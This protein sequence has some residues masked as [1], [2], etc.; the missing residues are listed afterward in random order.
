FPHD[1]CV[2]HLFQRQASLTPDATA[3]RFGAESLSYARL[4]ALSNQLAHRLRLLG[5]RPGHVVALCVERSPLLFAGMLAILKAGA[6]YLPLD[7]T[8]PAQRRAFMLQDAAVQVIVGQ[9][10]L[11]DGFSDTRLAWLGVEE[12]T[13]TG[14]DAETPPESGATALDAAYVIYTSGSTSH[15][16]GVVVPHRALVN[17]TLAAIEQ[18][19]LRPEDRAL[20]FAS[21]SFDASAEEIFPTLCRGAT[22]VPRTEAMLEST[23]AFLDA[24]REHAIS[25]LNLPTA[26]WHELTADLGNGPTVLPDSVRLIIIGGEKASPEHLA[27]WRRQVGSHPR[28]VNTYGPT[29][30]TIVATLAELAESSVPDGAELPIGRP[31]RNVRVHVL[32][33]RLHPVPVGVTGELFIGGEGVAR[34]YL[35]RPDLTAERFLPDPFS[36]EPGAR[37]YRTGDLVRWRS[38]TGL[39]Y[40]GRNDHQVKLRG[41]RI[42][43]GEIEAQLLAHPH[44][45]DSV[46]APRAYSAHDTRL[47]AW[48]TLREDGPAVTEASVEASLRA[49]LADRLP[50]YMLPF[51]IQVLERLPLT[52]NGK[53][54]RAAL[55][56]PEAGAQDAALER[57]APRDATEQVLA[58]LWREVLS[59][60]EPDMRDDFFAVG[61][62]SL[63]AL[64]LMGRIERRLGVALPLD[65]LFHAPTLEALARQVRERTP[66][67]ASSLRVL[68][69][70]GD[71]GPPV[72]LIHPVGGHLLCYHE[73]VRRL[74]SPRTLYGLQAPGAE[75]GPVEPATLEALAERYIEQLREV[76]PT[77]P[78]QLAGWSVGGVIAFEMARQLTRAGQE[79][80]TLVA[81]DALPANDADRDVTEEEQ[82]SEAALLLALDSGMPEAEAR[83]R[84]VTQGVSG[85]LMHVQQSADLPAERSRERVQHMLQLFLRNARAH[86]QYRPQPLAG[87]LVLIEAR[88]RPAGLAPFADVWRPLIQGALHTTVV[89]GSH[90][91]V[92]T[93]PNVES[94]ARVLDEALGAAG[95]AAPHLTAAE[96]RGR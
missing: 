58:D 83:E 48:V 70:Q 52:A 80:G 51:R 37:L 33:T 18:Y 22:L 1:A 9:E 19:G 24:C 68:L 75:G 32:D 4:D 67:R 90:D 50:A 16:K 91:T 49:H 62:H 13:G 84:L 63:L 69:R 35:G 26:F 60:G 74:R 56:L 87:S 42:E 11:R 15:P 57:Q 73:L 23:R 71:D 47:V 43:L 28:L 92:L 93:A 81:I 94:V 79:V 77:G 40:V 66:G 7:P 45:R 31:V 3:L 95:A 8:L 10:H 2:H 46:V 29:E 20:Q 39:T 30:A 12:A 5:V 41:F 78:Y 14:Q 6:A 17:Y 36:S 55:P 88:E 34:G 64:R 82:A 59:T 76:Q 27:R 38:E 53:V 54:D 61:G 96:R 44:V 89:P 72:F 21:V 85:L 25:V 65:T 86:N